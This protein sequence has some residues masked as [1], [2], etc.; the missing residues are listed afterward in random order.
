[1]ATDVRF[2]VVLFDLDGT[3]TDSEAGIVASYRYALRSQGLSA[4]YSA[5]RSCIGPPLMQSLRHLGV[6]VEDVERAT[7]AF[8]EYMVERGMYENRLYDGIVQALGSL[9]SAGMVMGIATSKLIDVALPIVEHFGISGFFST[10]SGATADG[11]RAHK[12][13]IAAHALEELGAPKPQSVAMVGDREHDMFA[14]RD[15]GLFAVG[16]G[17]GYGGEEELLSSGADVILASPVALTEFLL[18]T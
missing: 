6:P 8:R 1:V 3:L 17:W 18:A 13:D 4:D 14:A 5:I 9:R 2:P 10:V 16:A 15:L 7:V 11:H 12:V